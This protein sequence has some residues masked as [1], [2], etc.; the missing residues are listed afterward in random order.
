MRNPRGKWNEE[1]NNDQDSRH[2]R[3]LHLE[4]FDES[5]DIDVRAHENQCHLQ[6][7]SVLMVRF[8]KIESLELFGE[9]REVS[10]KVQK[11]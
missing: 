1:Q 2:K 7:G 5:F 6:L 4:M 8:L 3:G 11:P 10:V 9:C